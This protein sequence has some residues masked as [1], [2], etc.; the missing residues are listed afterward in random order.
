M[1]RQ[2]IYHQQFF[3]VGTRDKALASGIYFLDLKCIVLLSASRGFVVFWVILKIALYKL[4]LVVCDLSE[5]SH[6][7]HSCCDGTSSHR[8]L[9]TSV[10]LF[11][12]ILSVPTLCLK[13]SQTRND[14]IHPEL[15]LTVGVIRWNKIGWVL[16]T[17]KQE[18]LSVNN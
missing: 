14:A 11:V 12:H 7:F 5:P 6:V 16:A 10:S 1:Q 8:P 13:D 15:L 2:V 3:V 4:T 18:E 17:Q 9:Q